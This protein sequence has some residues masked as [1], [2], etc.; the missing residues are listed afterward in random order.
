MYVCRLWS[1]F[2]LILPS[3]QVGRGWGEGFEP[4]CKPG[5]FSCSSPL[6]I[7]I[8]MGWWRI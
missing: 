2:P 5:T 3:P 7:L 6:T 4:P 1:F 8:I